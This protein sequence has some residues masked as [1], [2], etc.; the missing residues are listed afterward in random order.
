MSAS[1]EQIV[2]WKKTILAVLPKEDIA[3]KLALSCLLEEIIKQSA[4]LVHAGII[5]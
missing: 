3:A 4:I 5:K 2:E 1:P